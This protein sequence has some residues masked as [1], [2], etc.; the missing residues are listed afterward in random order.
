MADDE[1]FEAAQDEY[2]AAAIEYTP[3][4]APG[5]KLVHATSLRKP[6]ETACGRKRGAHWTAEPRR[7]TCK[8]CK[9]IVCVDVRPS[10]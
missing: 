9:L 5:G 3:I 4:K 2:K 8:K 7:L 1:E 10:S 6:Q